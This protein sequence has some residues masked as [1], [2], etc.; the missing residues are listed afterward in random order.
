M[1]GLCNASAGNRVPGQQD[2]MWWQFT[3][4]NKVKVITVMSLK[5]K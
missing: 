1:T 2:V 5:L 3:I 4:R